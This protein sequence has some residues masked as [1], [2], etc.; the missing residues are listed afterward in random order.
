MAEGRYHHGNLRAALVE[1]ATALISAHGVDGWSISAASRK[2]GVT[3][4]A[5]YKH[6][7]NKAAL[8]DAV[9]HEQMTRFADRLSAAHAAEREPRAQLLATGRVVLWQ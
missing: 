1:T 5:A 2:L 6:F 7:A 8:V 4:A 3:H 9:T